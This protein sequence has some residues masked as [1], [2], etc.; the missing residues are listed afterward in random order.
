MN[1]TIRQRADFSVL[2]KF[3]GNYT[4][5]V[6]TVCFYCLCYTFHKSETGTAIYKIG[7]RSG[8]A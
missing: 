8:W 4:N 1:N 7:R 2:F 5:N 6:S 3:G